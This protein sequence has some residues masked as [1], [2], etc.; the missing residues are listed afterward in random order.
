MVNL[1]VAQ[2]CRGRL[3]FTIS[4]SVLDP[5]LL[6]PVLSVRVTSWDPFGRLPRFEGLVTVH[7]IYGLQRKT[8]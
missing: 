2:P 8:L 1:V 6:I 3:D 5:V 4:L 7:R